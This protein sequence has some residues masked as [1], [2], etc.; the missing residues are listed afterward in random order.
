MIGAAA[1]RIRAVQIAV[2]LVLLGLWEFVPTLLKSSAIVLFN[3]VFIST[4]SRIAADLY[5]ITFV[6]GLIFPALWSTL[7][8]AS[9]C[10]DP[11]LTNPL[12]EKAYPIASFTWLLVYKEQTD[13]AKG[14]AIVNFLHWA[15]TEGQKY[16]ADLLYAPLP[17]QVAQQV[18][19]KVGQIT[20]HGKPL[21]VA[22]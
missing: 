20:F 3:P 6:S 12:G 4:P 2:L 10:R 14:K 19:A 8:A 9:F 7:S 11:S 18:R 13:E 15:T 17:P 5:Q 21:L 1:L 16:A 22:R